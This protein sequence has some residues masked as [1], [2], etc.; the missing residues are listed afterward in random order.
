MIG[1]LEIAILVVIIFVV[2]LMG[3]H[4][5]LPKIGRSA[6]EGAKAGG[7]KAKQVAAT[8]GE[9]ASEIDTEK[10][11]KTA[12]DGLREAKEV[13]EALTGKG[14]PEDADEEPKRPEAAAP[15]PEEP[16]P[17]EP[18]PTESSSSSA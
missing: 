6:G 9:K 15:E 2:L 12:G 13:R 10:I 18:K 5:W 16:K 1:P 14:K 7:Q 3:G 4:K 8:V 11:A 17:A